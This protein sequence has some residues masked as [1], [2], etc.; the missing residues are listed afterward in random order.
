MLSRLS[1]VSLLSLML[2]ACGLNDVAHRTADNTDSMN[3]QMGTMTQNTEEMKKSTGEMKDDTAALKDKMGKMTE[4]LEQVTSNMKKVSDSVT[5]VDSKV[6]ELGSDGRQAIGAGIRD[7]AWK[8]MMES[9]F[10]ER[11]F[12]QAGIY[13]SAFEFQIW[14]GTGLDTAERRDSLRFDAA[15]EFLRSVSG[16][17]LKQKYSMDILSKDSSMNDLFAISALLHFVNPNQELFAQKNGF[18]PESM[19]DIIENGMR[20]KKFLAEGKVTFEEITNADKEVQVWWDASEY[21]IRLR[22]NYLAAITTFKLARLEEAQNS[23][24]E[25]ARQARLMI[26]PWNPAL[27]Y[28]SSL[29]GAIKEV[30]TYLRESTKARKFLREMNI[31]PKTDP[32]LK[33]AIKNINLD[34]IQIEAFQ[35]KLDKKSGISREFIETLKEFKENI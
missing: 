35:M 26:G 28:Y 8:A 22:A 25:K 18:K 11:K 29:P 20:K 33:I 34:P 21:L 12:A 15:S 2:S 7:S 4:S 17:C 30:T 3:D 10:V 31:D 9:E 23:L 32:K 5:A 13:Y 6:H 19:L 16:A 14:K 24:D 27:D 1:K